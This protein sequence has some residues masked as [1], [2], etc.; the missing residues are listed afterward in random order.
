MKTIIVILI[1]LLIPIKSDGQ[2]VDYL[3][4]RDSLSH[5]ICGKPD[6]ISAIRTLLSLEAFDS[7][8]LSKNIVYYYYDLGMAYYILYAFTKD[9]NYLRKSIKL[10]EKI[11]YHK[12]QFTNALWNLS[13]SYSFIG[14]CTK[15]KYYLKRYKKSIPK[16]K[17]QKDQIKYLEKKCGK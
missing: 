11:L 5:S 4:V 13:I 7:N 12:S 16:R 17:W 8:L 6:S 2:R 1:A 15:S 14:N 9:T 3:L 10:D